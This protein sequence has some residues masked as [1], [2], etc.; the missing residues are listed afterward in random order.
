MMFNVVHVHI[1]MIL[2]GV[3][4]FHVEPFILKKARW[5]YPFP[6]FYPFS[7]FSKTRNLL[8]LQTWTAV[9]VVWA[10]SGDSGLGKF[11][12]PRAKMEYLQSF[13]Q[14]NGFKS[15][16]SP[17][18]VSMGPHTDAWNTERIFYR[19]RPNDYIW[20]LTSMMYVIG[21]FHC[22]R[23]YKETYVRVCIHPFIQ[24]GSHPCKH[25]SIA[26]THT[27]SLGLNG[28]THLEQWLSHALLRSELA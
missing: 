8:T 20:M 1:W 24:T 14:A 6:H 13:L 3:V 11:A 22:I 5:L 23:T 27:F 26:H 15:I 12:P 7:T 28:R 18:S 17:L 10:L 2:T 21:Y 25:T 19:M 4:W 9:D 16:S